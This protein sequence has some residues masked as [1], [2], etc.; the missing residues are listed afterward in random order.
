MVIKK[1][2][3]AIVLL[4]IIILAPKCY[5]DQLQLPFSCYPKDLQQGFARRGIKLDID[6]NNRTKESWGFLENKG[7]Y[8]ILVTYKPVTDKDFDVIDAVTE[9]IRR[10][11]NG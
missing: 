8:Y 5:C 6:S 7:T 9:E 11:T 10:E 1:R 4:L 2:I 3:I